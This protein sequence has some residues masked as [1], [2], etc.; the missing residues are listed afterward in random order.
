MTSLLW[1][2]ITGSIGGWLAGYLMH[3]DKTF[4]ITDVIIGVLGALAG[5]FL[6]TFI[7]FLR[8]D[9]VIGEILKSA[10]GAV[11]LTWGY[12]WYRQRELRG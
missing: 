10:F 9:S 3:R 8:L 7:P 12:E 5:G 4:D 11:V 6:L 1:W 2:L